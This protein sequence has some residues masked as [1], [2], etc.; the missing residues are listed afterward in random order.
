M[1]I[2]S[3]TQT[4]G[5]FPAVLVRKQSWT[6]MYKSLYEYMFLFLLSKHFLWVWELND[7]I[8]FNK[9]SNYF[10]K[11]LY[12]LQSHPQ[13]KKDTA[14]HTL[15]SNCASQ[16]LNIN[17]SNSG[18]MVSHCSFNVYSLMTNGTEIFSYSYF[19]LI[20]H[21]QRNTFCPIPLLLF[22]TGLFVFDFTEF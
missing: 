14:T 21:L 3:P 6:F 9:L 2:H 1:L 16:P 10:P 12:I 15:I 8:L 11:C 19:P 4:S 13:C 18:V 7:C 17:H 22:F 20:Y 5:L